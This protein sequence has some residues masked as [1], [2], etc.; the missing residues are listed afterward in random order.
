M[1]GRPVSKWK[2]DTHDLVVRER[3]YTAAFTC[4]N[5]DTNQ[6]VTITL[7]QLQGEPA[8]VLIGGLYVLAELLI[9]MA[10]GDGPDEPTSK[11]TIN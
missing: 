1:G 6:A 5:S 4:T 11:R 8:G 9:R 10:Q 2:V 3:D 7:T